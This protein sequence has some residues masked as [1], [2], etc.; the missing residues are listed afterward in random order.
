ML[1][2]KPTLSR[3]GILAN[4][5]HLESRVQR[6]QDSWH[7]ELNELQYWLEQLDLLNKITP[8]DSSVTTAGDPHPLFNTLK[9]GMQ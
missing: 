5:D 8:D 2:P 3:A 4:I 7:S 6:A 9:G 1:D